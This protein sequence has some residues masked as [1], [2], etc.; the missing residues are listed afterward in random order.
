[1]EGNRGR[2][3]VRLAIVAL[4]LDAISVLLL[5]PNSKQGWLE[6]VG[7]FQGLGGFIAAAAYPLLAWLVANRRPENLLARLFLLLGLSQAVGNLA[8]QWAGLVYRTGVDAPLGDI[9]TWLG[10]WTWAPGF[11]FLFSVLL[12]YPDGSLPSRRWRPVAWLAGLTIAAISVM[13]AASSW[14]YRG[15]QL[16][17]PNFVPPEGDPLVAAAGTVV[18]IGIIAIILTGILQVVS[19]VVRYRR[20]SGAA[21]SQVRWVALAAAIQTVVTIVANMAGLPS[22]LDLIVALVM[23]PLV[24][25]AIVNAVT[26]HGLYGVGS[27]TRRVGLLASDTA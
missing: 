5:V 23:T 18:G 6:A 9:A 21:R 27:E 17:D 20:S 13:Q 1:M 26:S 19:L 12:V 11:V 10:S 14:S 25:L 2:W 16:A 7:G 24:P 15:A 3:I 8:Q 4:A 22:P